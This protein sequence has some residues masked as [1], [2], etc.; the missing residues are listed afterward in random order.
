MKLF[1][2]ECMGTGVPRALRLVGVP[3]VAH[4]RQV[5]RWKTQRGLVVDD[6]EWLA[7]VGQR[8]WLAITEDLRILENVEER[9]LIHKHDVG[10]VFV[11]AAKLQSRDVMAFMLRRLAWLER[12]DQEKRPFAYVTTL[13]GRPVK[14]I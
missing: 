11:K 1:F 13:R 7:R 2:D 10:I 8:Q 12:I 9:K 6:R 4:L 5:Y 3:D 14:E